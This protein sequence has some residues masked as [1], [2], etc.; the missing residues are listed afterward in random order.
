LRRERAPDGGGLTHRCCCGCRKTVADLDRVKA[1]LDPLRAGVQASLEAVARCVRQRLHQQQHGV[2][3]RYLHGVHHH[4]CGDRF[5]LL[6]RSLGAITEERHTSALP[7]LRQA[8][9]QAWERVD[10]LDGACKRGA[11]TGT[12]ERGVSAKPAPQHVNDEP[13]LQRYAA[14]AANVATW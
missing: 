4:H 11:L 6:L 3:C 13:T 10:A 9:A 14:I 5:C 12:C 8:L 2:H 7:Q 1:H